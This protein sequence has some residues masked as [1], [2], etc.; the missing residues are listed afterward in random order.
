[1]FNKFVEVV[2]GHYVD[3][4]FLNTNNSILTKRSVTGSINKGSS[5]SDKDTG[6]MQVDGAPQ[7]KQ[8]VMEKQVSKK[9]IF[10]ASINL[11]LDAVVV[12]ISS[13]FQ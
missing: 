5:S 1:M 3:K 8:S 11:V 6:K 13:T 2:N 9:I 12:L 7:R 10:H 4:Y